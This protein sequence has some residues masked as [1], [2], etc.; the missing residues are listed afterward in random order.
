MELIKNSIEALENLGSLVSRPVLGVYWAEAKLLAGRT[1]PILDVSRRNLELIEQYGQLGFLSPTRLTLAHALLALPHPNIEEGEAELQRCL[2][3]ALEQ[4]G[5]MIEVRAAT[6]LARLW[7][8]QDKAED[9]RAL[10]APVYG[11]FT[12]GFDTP[13]LKEAKTL[14]DEL[15]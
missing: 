5:K 10:L 7:Q 15:A 6:T 14:L 8:S 1:E 11:W 9:A 12:E 4:V 13:D 2:Q 3:V